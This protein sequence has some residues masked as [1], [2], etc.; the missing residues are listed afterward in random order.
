MFW[1]WLNQFVNNISVVLAPILTG[2]SEPEHLGGET[3]FGCL[4]LKALNRVMVLEGEQN[5]S[6]SVGSS[7]NLFLGL[8]GPGSGPSG[9]VSAVGEFSRTL[10][11][12]VNKV[13]VASWSQRQTNL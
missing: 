4:E 2:P 9:T 7:L 11:P 13:A 1:F 8:V 12:S 5:R 3:Q 6:A 10:V